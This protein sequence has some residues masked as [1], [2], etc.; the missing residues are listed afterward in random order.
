MIIE[1]YEANQGRMEKPSGFSF[2][3]ESGDVVSLT[4]NKVE[5]R[6]YEPSKSNSVQ[7][8]TLFLVMLFFVCL[9]VIMSVASATYDEVVKLANMKPASSYGSLGLPGYE[10]YNWDDVVSGAAGG[11]VRFN[12]W[13][14]SESINSWITDWLAV[15][16]ADEYDITLTLVPLKY[17]TTAV[18]TVINETRAGYVNNG[19]IDLIWINGHNFYNLKSGGY[20]Y[21]PWSDVVPSSELYDWNDKSIAYDFGY[22][23][24]GYEMPYT[25][26]QVVFVR[27]A[28]HV[29]EDEVKTY[30]DFIYWL[31]T[32]GKNKF[33]YPAPCNALLATGTCSSGD[34]TGAVFIRHVLYHVLDD[35]KVDYTIFDDVSI[36]ESVYAKWAPKLFKKLRDLESFLYKDTAN[37]NLINSIYPVSISVQ[38]S[39]FDSMD[40]YMTLSY[41]PTA[42]SDN[43][44]TTYPSTA[45][46]FVFE[47]DVGTIANT[48]YVMIPANSP[49]KLAALVAG[50]VIGSVPAMFSRAKI[51]FLSQVYDPDAEAFVSDGWD[52][53]FALLNTS[54]A[55]PST[56][57]LAK[58]RAG[59]IGAEY[60]ERFTVDWYWC[61]QNYEQGTTVVTLGDNSKYRIYCD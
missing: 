60:S 27:C 37:P 5:T 55:D 1:V 53:P 40:V 46:G 36:D 30:D 56:A 6:N 23:V 31:E 7:K 17:T 12:T 38:D 29:D 26:A 8:T 22:P 14:G 59:E 58:H 15:Q 2:E 50:N 57:K 35:A 44:G 52:V 21:G 11:E 48:N 41:N 16:L 34:H 28:M 33:T 45:V 25:G 61:V 3:V 13:N 47:D 19:T 9:V 43:I 49:N 32:S 24:D 18:N 4:S 42:A 20:A 39:L 54:S 10:G 51:N